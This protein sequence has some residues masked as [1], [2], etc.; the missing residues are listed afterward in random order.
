[1]KQE[2]LRTC[3]SCGKKR[4]KT[5]MLR[6]VIRDRGA[7]LDRKMRMEGRGFYICPL[8]DC[9]TGLRTRSGKAR[10]YKLSDEHFNTIREEIASE[11][12]T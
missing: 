4:S 12:L 8:S 6:F 10:K 9:L 3:I 5:S 11:V 7:V 2:P 1:M